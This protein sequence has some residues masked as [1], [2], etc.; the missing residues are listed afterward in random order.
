MVVYPAD[1]KG[2]VKFGDSGQ[3]VLEIANGLPH[4]VTDDDD[5]NDAGLRR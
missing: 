4:I 1:M 5:D 3:N 2:R